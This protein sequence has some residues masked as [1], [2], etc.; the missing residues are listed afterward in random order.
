MP[1]AVVVAVAKT[2]PNITA[3]AEAEAVVAPKRTP[4]EELEQRTPAVVVAVALMAHITAAMAA[5]AS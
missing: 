5:P 3:Q 1:E 2:I 4:K